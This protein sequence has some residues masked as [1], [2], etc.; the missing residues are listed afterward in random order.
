MKDENVYRK[1]DNGRYVPF[2]V[3]YEPDN[4]PDGIWYVRHREYSKST[5][6]VPY[7]QGLFKV[8]DAKQVDITELCGME[9]LCDYIMESK[10]FNDTVKNEEGCTLNDI[11]HVCVKKLVDKAQEQKKFQE[12]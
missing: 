6:S 9:D 5:T 11:V 7:M 1:M 10:E 3:C 8:G 4:M 12:V 2:G